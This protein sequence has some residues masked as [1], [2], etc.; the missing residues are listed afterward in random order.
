MPRLASTRCDWL[1]CVV[2]CNLTINGSGAH[3]LQ[4]VRLAVATVNQTPLDWPGNLSRMVA[5]IDD[6]R[7]Q[8]AQLI[9]LPELCVTG[10]GC[11]D[12]HFAV[13]VQQGAIDVVRKLA[14]HCQGLAVVVGTPV[15]VDSSLYNG[16]AMIVDGEIVGI[17]L[18]QHMATDGIHYESRWFRPWPTDT[19]DHVH[20]W[21]DG[22]ALHVGDL[23]YDLGGIKIGIEICRDAWV[24]RR[25]GAQYARRGADILLNPSASHFAFGKQRIRERFVLESSR[26][27]GVAYA[28]CNLLGNESGRSVYDGGRLVACGGKM[29]ARGTL[30]GYEDHGITI[31]DIDIA[32]NRRIRVQSLD[33]GPRLTTAGGWSD[34]WLNEI[35]RSLEWQS[36][37]VAVKRLANPK[38]WEISS[39]HKLEEFSRAVPLALFDYLRK[40][41]SHG[42]VVS[43]SGGA[44]SSAVALLVALSIRWALR[45]LGRQR[46]AE[47]LGYIPGIAKLLADGENCGENEIAKRLTH[48][49][50]TCV[51]QATRQSSK[52]TLDAARSV[53]NC[54]GAEFL[55]WNVDAMVDSYVTT[56]GDALGRNLDWEHDDIALQNIQA[57][58]RGPAVWMVANIR[59][60]LLLA[61]SN[62]SEAAVGYATM[63]GDTCGGLSPIAGIDKDFLRQWLRWMQETGVQEQQGPVL[64]PLPELAAITSQPPTAELRPAS[65]D[66]TDESDLMPYDVLDAIERLAI[67]DK[68]FPHDVL[69]LVEVEF[70]QFD[71]P[72][73]CG[74]VVRFFRLWCRNQWKRERYAPS[75][76]VDDESLDPKA[77]CRFP[78]LNSG[79][80]Q[81][82]AQL[83]ATLAE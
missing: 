77:W 41:R 43:A 36:Q 34:G 73:L 51:Y 3:H 10:Y 29:I 58:A 5:V 53:A 22:D 76:H 2:R 20:G 24:A 78:I 9:C 21:L 83:E 81:E 42:F 39:D 13:D 65:A 64:G 61:T 68:K 8:G 54:I 40:S 66:Q 48:E 25:I 71:R 67:R 46:L 59:N 12:M 44:D 11:E 18:K 16:A 14:E 7:E 56:V 37:P 69:S 27:F 15:F 19:D 80:E 26:A 38:A 35:E 31:A 82:L 63:D 50:L 1:S 33:A 47:R 72:T 49:L 6:A 32:N 4:Y 52:Q 30:F 74:W 17:S 45:E 79:F 57:R 28:Y 55:D 62:R 75:F 23:L 60:R 70:P